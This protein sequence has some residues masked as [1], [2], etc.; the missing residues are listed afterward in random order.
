MPSSPPR[1]AKHTS[2]WRHEQAA[3]LSLSAYL[4]A[5]ILVFSAVAVAQSALLVLVVTAPGIG[6]RAPATAAVLGVPMLELFV[7]V[8]ATAAPPPDSAW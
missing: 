3:G 6:K 7:D 1:K 5:K 4:L 2:F 8:A